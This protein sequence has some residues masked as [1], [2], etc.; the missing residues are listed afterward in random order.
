MGRYS[1]DVTGQTV[2]FGAIFVIGVVMA[3]GECVATV[4]NFGG[5][6]PIHQHAMEQGYQYLQEHYPSA[7]YQLTCMSQDTDN[8][9][10]VT[11]SATTEEVGHPDRAFECSE[12][13]WVTSNPGCKPLPLRYT[14]Q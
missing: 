4:E 1:N 12:Y 3:V 5:N 8:N 9:G 6:G 7:H 2:L 13:T 11:C 10:Y 14:G